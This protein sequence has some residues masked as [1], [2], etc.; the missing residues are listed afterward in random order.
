MLSV[1]KT[2]NVGPFVNAD[3]QFGSRVNVLTGNN[4]TGKSF[5][6][7]TVWWAITGTWPN[8]INRNV[9]AGYTAR[10]TSHDTA[11]ISF[12]LN[13]DVHPYVSTFHRRQQEWRGTNKR[14][15]QDGVVVYAMSDGN[16]AVW[17]SYRKERPAH[18]FSHSDILDG[19]YTKNGTCVCNGFIRDVDGWK[20]EN[21]EALHVFEDLLHQMSMSTSDHLTLGPLTRIS[22]DDIRDIPTI[23]T[24]NNQNV[25]ILMVSAGVRR[26][27]M[28]AYLLVWTSTEHQ[29]LAEI[30]GTHADSTLTLMVD[31]IEDHL[32]PERQRVVLPSL[33][34]AA[35]SVNGG[36]HVQSF[37]TT[38]APLVMCSTEPLFQDN[39]DK[40]FGLDIE[41]QTITVSERVF[42]KQGDVLNWLVSDAFGLKSGRALEY[43][44]LID[45]AQRFGD[46]QQPSSVEAAE[47]NEK[48]VS[49]LPVNDEFLMRWHFH[50]E[51]MGLLKQ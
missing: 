18:V 46:V 19:L 13:D 45:A 25:P 3:L 40:W 10:P 37:F 29:R 7:N 47:L 36:M 27:C 9:M 26:L 1:L 41:N 11:Q 31:D 50:C 33:I 24:R 39:V 43:E 22:L 14:P 28:L 38:H 48:L 8:S 44:A 4:G 32:H 42:A 20:K 49:A 2:S 15:V 6:L 17:D 16:F 21:G 51:K 34:K 5:L 35:E 23:Q 12:T 30:R